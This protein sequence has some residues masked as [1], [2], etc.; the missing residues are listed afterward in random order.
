MMFTPYCLAAFLF[1]FILIVFGVLKR[2]KLLLLGG[3]LGVVGPLPGWWFG[4]MGRQHP[5]SLAAL[6][7]LFLIASI[8][9]FGGLLF[10]VPF[11]GFY[12][13]IIGLIGGWA[14]YKLGQKNMP[15]WA[16]PLMIAA[17]IILAPLPWILGADPNAVDAVF[18][19]VFWGTIFFI[20]RI[21]IFNEKILSK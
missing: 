1:I 5:F 15:S 6:P 10:F 8:N 2:S 19:S 13:S 14:I 17:L 18:A 3:I 21:R 16:Q 12:C 20:F 9:Y 11:F 4:V 7:R